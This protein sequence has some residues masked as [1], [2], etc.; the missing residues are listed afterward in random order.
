MSAILDQLN[1]I[2]NTSNNVDEVLLATK[3]L[4]FAEKAKTANFS[5]EVKNHKLGLIV[6]AHSANIANSDSSN[7]QFWKDLLTQHYL[8]LLDNLLK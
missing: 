4:Q 7:R 6:L 3:L 1:N 8:T 2:K 5:D